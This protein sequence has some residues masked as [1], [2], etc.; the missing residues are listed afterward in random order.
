MVVQE[1]IRTIT[2]C[3]VRLEAQDSSV[4]IGGNRGS[5]PLRDTHIAS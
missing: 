2:A 5:T 1:Y 3:P 4:S